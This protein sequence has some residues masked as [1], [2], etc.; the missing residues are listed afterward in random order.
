[1]LSFLAMRGTGA[2]S[3]AGIIEPTAVGIRKEADTSVLHKDPSPEFVRLN[4]PINYKSHSYN[5]I[6]L[7]VIFRNI[8]LPYDEAGID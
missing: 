2:E 7:S 3:G 1:M 6:K 4:I 8:V 5:Y